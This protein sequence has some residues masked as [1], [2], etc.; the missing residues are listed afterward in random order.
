MHSAHK[1]SICLPLTI[2]SYL[3]ALLLSLK[4]ECFRLYFSLCKGHKQGRHYIY[5]HVNEIIILM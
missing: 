2:T 3:I 4:T 5:R 1:V